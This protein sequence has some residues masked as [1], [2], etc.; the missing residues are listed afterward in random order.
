VSTNARPGTYTA[1]GV[2]YRQPGPCPRNGS[3]AITLDGAAGYVSG[4]TATQ[5]NPAPF[6]VEIW[7]QTTTTRGGKLIG[8][9]DVRT[10]Q[11]GRYDRHLY[12]ANNGQLYFGVYAGA[13]RTFTGPSAYNDGRWHHAVATLSPTA[14]MALYVD[15]AVVATDANTKTAENYAGFWRIGGDNVNGWTSQPASFFLAGSLAYPAVYT[16]ALTAV[17]VRARYLAGT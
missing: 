1:S 13:V 15:G 11:S 17:Q 6:S 12:L 14:G 8:F 2:S 5:T 10:G 16:V 3:R 9:A 4:P 7:F